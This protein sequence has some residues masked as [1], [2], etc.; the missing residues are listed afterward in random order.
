[1]V[2]VKIIR[3]PANVLDTYAGDA[4]IQKIRIRYTGKKIQ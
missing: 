3:N 2:N 1:M 4:N